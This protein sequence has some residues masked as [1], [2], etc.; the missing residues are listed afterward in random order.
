MVLRQPYSFY[1]SQS[2]DFFGSTE[3]LKTRSAPLTLKSYFLCLHPLRWLKNLIIF[4]PLLFQG[5]SWDYHYFFEL[6][7]A[8]SLFSLCASNL[9]LINDLIDFETDRKDEVRK[10]RQLASL[11][12]STKESKIFSVVTFVIWFSSSWYYNQTVAQLLL[13]YF[14]LGLLYTIWVKQLFLLDCV[15]LS[16]F[17]VLRAVLG[18]SIV[19]LQI[20]ASFFIFLFLLFCSLAFLKR[21][22]ELNWR[23]NED[24]KENLPGRSYSA[25]H[26]PLLFNLGILLGLSCGIV[27]SYSLKINSLAYPPAFETVKW[28]LVILLTVWILDLWRKSKARKIQSDP[29][30][31]VL[32]SKTS[33]SFAFFI[34]VAFAAA[35]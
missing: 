4:V 10:H 32:K 11:Q 29:Y 3:T 23:Q 26:L 25:K 2:A 14:V 12:V 17:Y 35:I 7:I 27:L 28:L 5:K 8:F 13:L 22:A 18:S 30:H 19:N 21:H 15:L 6:T 1:L 31:Y 16:F 9:Y 20:S 34:V 33:W 24:L